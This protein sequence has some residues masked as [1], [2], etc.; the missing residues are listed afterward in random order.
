MADLPLTFKKE[1][2]SKK[3]KILDQSVFYNFCQNSFRK[4]TGKH[5]KHFR[6][7]L[8]FCRQYLEN[9]LSNQLSAF[10]KKISSV[11]FTLDFGRG[12]APNIVYS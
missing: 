9:S 3:K 5:L 1:G 6:W 12:K 4:F 11:N 2:K 8:W 7:P 10:F